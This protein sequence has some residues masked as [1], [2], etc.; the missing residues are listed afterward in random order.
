MSFGRNGCAPI[1]LALLFTARIY[2]VGVSQINGGSEAANWVVDK[3][4]DIVEYRAINAP[5][6]LL[7]PSGAL[8]TSPEAQERRAAGKK[9]AFRC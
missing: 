1:W 8:D 6:P 2:I 3:I 4:N 5:Q 7:G 9:V